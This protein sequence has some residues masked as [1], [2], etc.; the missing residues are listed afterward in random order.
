MHAHAVSQPLESHIADERERTCSLGTQSRDPHCVLFFCFVVVVAVVG[1]SQP[2][3]LQL[4]SSFVF[5]CFDTC[6][7]AIEPFGNVLLM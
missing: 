4:D 3:M 5:M 2:V 7:Y 6:L 1:A